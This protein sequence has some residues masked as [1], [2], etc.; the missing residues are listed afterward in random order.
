[1]CLVG[2][3]AIGLIFGDRVFPEL[4]AMFGDPV[5]DI[6][7]GAMGALFAVIAYETVAMLLRPD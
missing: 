3:M 1:V 2:G 7:L 4:E 5:T 6:F